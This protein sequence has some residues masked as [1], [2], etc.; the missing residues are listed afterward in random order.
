M[1]LSSI[2]LTTLATGHGLRRFDRHGPLHHDDLALPFV[3]AVP[4]IARRSPRN[5]HGPCN[6]AH[7]CTSRSVL[8]AIT[9]SCDRFRCGGF[10]PW[11]HRLAH[12]DRPIAQHHQH[13]LSVDH[14][15]HWVHH[16]PL[17]DLF[18][19]CGKVSRN[20][21]Q[22]K[23]SGGFRDVRQTANHREGPKARP[24]LCKEGSVSAVVHAI[25]MPRDVP[26]LLRTVCSD[27]LPA[28]IRD[29]PRVFHHFGL[30][31]SLDRERRFI[32]G[33][34]PSRLRRRQVREVQLL[35][36]RNNILGHHHPVLDKG[37][38][39]S[40]TGH[41]VNCVWLRIGRKFCRSRSI[42]QRANATH[43][44]HPVSPASLRCSACHSLHHRPRNRKRYRFHGIVVSPPHFLPALMSLTVSAVRWPTCLS[45]ARLLRNTD[46]SRS[47]S[48]PALQCLQAVHFWWL[49]VLSRTADGARSSEARTLVHIMLS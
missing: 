42:L 41:L 1:G 15:D 23:L 35:Y 21:I 14:E 38:E 31:H 7:G 32:L 18:M 46:T 45:A 12:C 27:L 30:L 13:W 44:G 8:Q 34:D 5:L 6:V 39:C 9:R 25:D 22:V 17:P 11:R 29:R 24:Q 26:R 49:L 33:Q 4:L 19:C 47:R 37:N 48:S 40:W 2:T 43:T 3:L 36:R 28:L 20:C 16:D 10:V